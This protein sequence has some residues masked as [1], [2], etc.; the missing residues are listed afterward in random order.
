MGR[1]YNED[2]HGYLRPLMERARDDWELLE[3]CRQAGCESSRG[4]IRNWLDGR[5]RSGK[6]GDEQEEHEQEEPVKRSLPPHV[7]LSLLRWVGEHYPEE[8]TRL[9]RELVARRPE[10]HVTLWAWAAREQRRNEEM[11]A[12]V[13]GIREAY[14]KQEA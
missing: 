2:H 12:L 13:M 7:A 10:P 9:Y 8:A 6:Q 14:R 3:V 11:L 1:N 5:V 4:S